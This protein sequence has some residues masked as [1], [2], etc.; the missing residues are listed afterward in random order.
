MFQLSKDQLTLQA[1][2][3][4]LAKSV[5]AQQ[6]EIIDRTEEYPWENVKKLATAGFMGMTIPQCYG[7]LCGQIFIFPH[8]GVLA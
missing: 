6:A 4:E 5:F 8:R 2:A 3:S 1:K 7:Y